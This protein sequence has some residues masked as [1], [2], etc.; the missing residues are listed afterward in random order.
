MDF[1]AYFT[2][3]DTAGRQAFADRAN[4]SVAYI[5]CHLISKPP[6]K[7]PL[8]THIVTL[9]EASQGNCTL[10]EVLDHFMLK[11]DADRLPPSGQ[12]QAMPAGSGEQAAAST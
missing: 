3:M 6:R 5:S 10:A 8:L 2:G 7:V 4:A 12:A 9:A 11:V 1:R